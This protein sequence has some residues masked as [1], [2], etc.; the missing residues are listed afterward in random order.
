[1]LCFSRAPTV[2]EHRSHPLSFFFSCF[3]NKRWDVKRET[4]QS[5]NA[6]FSPCQN[7]LR[8][9]SAGEDSA[10]N[11]A[12]LSLPLLTRCVSSLYSRA[13]V[14]S[15]FAAGFCFFCC[16]KCFFFPFRWCV[17]LLSNAGLYSN[18]CQTHICFVFVSPSCLCVTSC[19]PSLSWIRSRLL[20]ICCRWA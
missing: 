19:V 3:F 15:L 1:M 11:H 2:L 8:S 12:V 18:Q 14:W 9:L 20:W 6:H 16:C 10:C 13:H 17:L 4:I 7:V 5:S